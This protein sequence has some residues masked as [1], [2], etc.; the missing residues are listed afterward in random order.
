MKGRRARG[1]RMIISRD[2]RIT[3]MCTTK[4]RARGNEMTISRDG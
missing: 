3:P 2:G 4:A 1:N